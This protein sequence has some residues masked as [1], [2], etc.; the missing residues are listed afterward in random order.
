VLGTPWGELLVFD[1]DVRKPIARGDR[2]GV[3]FAPN[4]VIVLPGTSGSEQQVIP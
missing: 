4:D 3:A 2:A 1:A